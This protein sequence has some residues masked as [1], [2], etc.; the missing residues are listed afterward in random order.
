MAPGRRYPARLQPI[1]GGLG[2]RH[3]LA[4]PMDQAGRLNVL[5]S[6]RRAAKR[7]GLDSFFPPCGIR[8]L[9]TCVTDAYDRLQSNGR[10]STDRPSLVSVPQGKVVWSIGSSLLQPES[11]QSRSDRRQQR[12][13]LGPNWDEL[14]PQLHVAD[15]KTLARKAP[16]VTSGR[17]KQ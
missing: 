2:T 12:R 3:V 14:A 13:R 8:H 1:S 7:S 4:I 16:L 15:R 10:P 11:G 17:D 6:N 5:I 9:T